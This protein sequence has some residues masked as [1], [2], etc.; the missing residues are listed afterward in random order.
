MR[1]GERFVEGA[2]AWGARAVRLGLGALVVACAPNLTTTGGAGGEGGDG[3]GGTGGSGGAGGGGGSGGVIVCPQAPN[4]PT[5]VPVA[6][7][8]GNYCIDSTEV[9]NSQ[10]AA[11]LSSANANEEKQTPECAFNTSFVPNGMTPPAN[12]RPVAFVDWC[13]AYAFCKSHGKRLCG[14][15]GG[16]PV[17]YFEIN[18]AAVSQ[19]HNACSRSG[20]FVF[21]YGNTYNPAA[22]NGHD[23]MVGSS[24]EA[25]T[26][27]SCE[28]GLPGLFDMSGNVWEWED[29]CDGSTGENDTCR[30]RGGGYE[31][32]TSD[33]DCP[34]AGGGARNASNETTGFRC[35][36]DVP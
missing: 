23:A 16:G 35:C 5:M 27:L 8:S 26:Q 14:K 12:D 22:C 36:V 18:N 13:D 10:Y 17:P 1:S 15:I 33:L 34:T 31:S 25:G 20:E 6:S 24:H 30:R 3:S 21:P 19:W 9:T 4:T 2:R 29:V 32:I 11:W 28:G 7:P